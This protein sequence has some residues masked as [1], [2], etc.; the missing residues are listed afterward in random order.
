M[1]VQPDFRAELGGIVN[2]ESLIELFGMI[3]DRAELEAEFVRDLR[4]R[5]AKG[6]VN[7]DF[8]LR[9]RRA[10]FAQHA[11]GMGDRVFAQFDRHRYETAFRIP[12]GVFGNSARGH[13]PFGFEREN[14]ISGR[15]LQTRRRIGSAVCGTGDLPEKL[16]NRRG[17]A[18]ADWHIARV[19]ARLSRENSEQRLEAAGLVD[20]PPVGR[21]DHLTAQYGCSCRGYWSL[22]LLAR[23]AGRRPPECVCEPGPE[24]IEELNVV[25]RKGARGAGPRENYKCNSPAVFG[26]HR[27]QN[28]A[29]IE[30]RLY[31]PVI[32][33]FQIVAALPVQRPT[34]GR[35]AD[36]RHPQR[37]EGR[38]II[39][40]PP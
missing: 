40:E 32:A 14:A 31:F 4:P 1:W 26:Y 35:G 24:P 11:G 30:R 13:E 9:R 27:V 34:N 29:G 6:K 2:I 39:H 10:A 7:S 36:P 22:I 19:I 17:Q 3:R 18:V 5:L 15:N 33:A 12:S 38:W 8:R 16:Q 20:D 23:I 28:P 25:H 37:H 21:Q